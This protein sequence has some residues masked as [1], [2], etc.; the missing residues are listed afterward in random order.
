MSHLNAIDDL[1][2]EIAIIGMSGRFPGAKNI[3]EFWQNL[4]DGVE[5]ISFFSEQELESL[6]INST[7]LK[8]ANYVRA[9]AVLEDVD[10]FDASFFGFAPREANIMDPQQRLFLECAWEA[11]EDAGYSSGTDAGSVGVFAGAS[12]NTYLLLNPSLNLESTPS[13]FQTLISNDKDF[14][15][16]RVSYK[17]NLNGPSI[18]IQSACSTSLVAVHL[19]CQ[20]LLNGECDMALAGGVSIYFPQKVGYLHQEEMIFSPDGHCRAFD[21]KAQGTIKGD[22]LGIVVLKRLV[23]ALADG[24]N[25]YAVIKGSAINNDGSLKVGYT[26]PSEDGQAQVIKDALTIARVMP[27]MIAYVEAHGT[28][29]TLGDPIEVA[30]L[31]QAF[32][33][34]TEAKG[35]C[36]IGSVKTNIGHLDVAAGVAGLIKTVLALKNKLLPPS[37]HFEQPNPHI[38][39]I[40][41]PFYVNTTAC[42]WETGET[43]RRA[44]V[45]SFGIGG[46]NAHVVLEEAP[47]PEF[48][49]SQVERPLHLL[50]LS[51]KSQRALMELAAK[52]KSQL[53]MHPSVPL[54]DVCY[55]A[56]VGRVHFPHRLVAVSETST[57]MLEKLASFANGEEAPELLNGHVEGMS[58]PKVAF[59]FAGQGSQY[60][61]MGRQLYE[62]QPTFR[63]TLARCDEILRPYL[64]QPLLSVL[65]PETGGTSRLDETAY[66]QPALFALEYALF[67]LWRSWSIEPDIVMGHSVGEYVAACVAGVFSLED[68]LK[69]VAERSRLM[70]SLPQDGKMAAVFATEERVK[71]AV[72]AYEEQV[73]IAAVNGSGNI[74]ISGAGEAVQSAIELLKSEGIVIQSLQVSHAFHSPSIDPILDEFERLAARVQFQPPSIPLISNLTGQMFKP[75]E[76]PDANY[77]RR[78]MRET[79]KFS[80][81]M[82]TLA[83]QGY[84]IFLELGPSTTLLSMG[85]R[86]LPKQKGFWLPSLKQGQD[87]WRVLLNS[88]ARLEIQGV[89]V[90]WAGFDRDYQRRRVSLPTYPFERK[91]YWMESEKP[92]SVKKSDPLLKAQVEMTPQIAPEDKSES[93]LR[94]I[95]ARLLQMNPD[96]ID[97]HAPFIEMGADSLVLIEA[98]GIIENTFGIKVAVRQFFEELTTIDALATYIDRIPKDSLQT[99]TKLDV[100]SQQSVLTTSVNATADVPKKE[101]SISV[102][103]TALERI[104]AQ[105]L[106]AMSQLMSQ[107]LEVLR[108]RGLPA[109]KSLSKDITSSKSLKRTSPN[110]NSLS[111]ASFQ[112]QITTNGFLDTLSSYPKP[113]QTNAEIIKSEP[114]RRLSPEQQQHLEALIASYTKRTQKSK[115]RKQAYHPVWAD[116]RGAAGFRLSIKEMLYPI[117]GQYS[118]GS[119]I[120]DIDGNEYIDITMGFGVHLFGHAVPFITDALEARLKQGIHLGP[121]S[122]LAGEV[123]E[124]ICKMTGV[125]RVTFCSSGTEAVM[126][127]LRLARMTTGRTKIALFSG[128]YHGHFD[129]VLATAQT[130]DGQ[131]RSVAIAPGVPQKIIEDVLVLDYGNPQSLEVIQAHA[132]EL[133][134]VLVE[135]VQ[136]RRPDLQ[137]RAF[138]Q[139]LRELTQATGT[140]LIFDEVITGFRIHPGGAQAWFGIAADLVTYG[141]VIGGGMPIGV[142]AGKATYM[143]GIDGGLWNY[144]DGSSPQA[145]KT[146]AAGTFN[147]HPLAM[148]STLAVLKHLQKAGPAL[149]QQLNQRTAQLAETLNAYFE[150]EDVPI[151]IVYFGSLFRFSFSG[152][153]DL[154]FYH[155]I[156]KGV[157]IW[158]GRN[159]FLSTA[160]TDEDINYIIRAVKESVES[161]RTG[162]F[163]LKRPANSQNGHQRSHL[164]SNT[165]TNSSRIAESTLT[166]H[167][168]KVHTVPLTEA[169]KQL[170][171]L[172]QVGDEGAMAYNLPLL[173]E[174]RGSLNLSALHTDVHKAIERHE[175]LRTTISNQGD[176]Q[177]ILPTLTID[178]PL[179]DFSSLNTAERET[180]VQQ[181][182]IQESQQCFD[183]TQGPLLRIHVLK[184][185]AEKHL[186]VFTMHHIIIDGW[187]M[188]VLLQELSVFY[189]AECKGIDCQQEPPLQFREY[190]QWQERQSQTDQ[191][192]EHEAYWLGQFTDSIPILELPS[193]RPRPSVKTYRGARASM[194]L[195]AT[196]YTKCQRLSR[197]K[198]CTLFMTLLATYIALLHRFT[199][200]DDIL[201][202]IPVAGRTLS[203]SENMV[204][205]CTHLLPIRSQLVGSPTFSEY[206]TKIRHVLLDAYEHQDYTFANLLKQLNLRT[207]PSRSPLVTAT[208]NLDRPKSMPKMFGL[209]VELVS[210]PISYAQFDID[211][212]IIESNGE[213]LLEVD[214]STDLFEAQKID[215]MLRHFQTLLESIV[216][217]P[218]Q[219]L[220][221]LSLLTQKERQQLLLEWNHTQTDYPQDACI[222][223]LFEAQV[224]RTPDAVAVVFADQNLT[225]FELNSRANQVAHHLRSLG[226]K[227]GT[228]VGLC[229]S[230]SLE[231]V[232]GLLGILKAGGAYVPLDPAYPSERLAFMLADSQLPVL[233]TQQHLVKLLPQHQARGVCLDTQWP[234]NTQYSQENLNSGVTSNHLAYLIYTSGSTGQPK[235][236]LINHQGLVNHGVAVA[237]E[238][239]LQV[240]DRILQFSSISFDIAAEELF[241]SWLAGATVVLRSGDMVS[242]SMD[243]WQV[244]EQERLT[245][246]NLPT[247]Y[248]HQWVHSLALSNKLLPQTLRLVVV[249]GEKASSA[250]LAMWRQLPGAEHVRWVNTYG[251]TEATIIVTVYEPGTLLASQEIPIGRPI[252]NTQIYLLDRQLQPVPIGIPGEIYIGGVPLARGYLNRPEQ[253]ALAFIRN[254]FSDTPGDRLYKTGDLA[255]YQSN[256]DIEYLGRIDDQVKIRGFRI[257][258]EE[259]E[260]VLSQH[261]AVQETVVIVREDVP[262]NKRLVAYVVANQTPIPAIAQLQQFLKQKLP[263]Y[264]VPTIIVFLDTLPLTPNSKLDR[265][266]LPAPDPA[267]SELAGSYVAPQTSAEEILAKIWAEVLGVKQVSIH[268]NFFELG[269][270]SILSIQIIARANQAG[271]VLTP[272]QLFFNQTIAE[273][274]TVAEISSV[275][276]IKQKLVTGEV[277]LTPIQRWFFE[278]EL[279][280]PHHWNQAMLLEVRQTLDPGLLEQ[281]VEQLL[282]HHDA[283]RL[284]F[285]RS[286]SGWQQVNALPDAVLPFTRVDLSWLKEEEQKPAIEAA[287]AELQASLNLAEGPLVRVALFD[288]GAKQPNRLLFI[289]HHL[290]VDGV[291]WRILLEDLQTT[292]Q[293]LNHKQAIALPPKTTSFQDWSQRLFEYARSPAL[294]SELD[295]WLTCSRSFVASVPVDD[296][297][298]DNTEASACTLSVSLSAEETHALLFEVPKAYH[299]QI[300]DALLTALVQTCAQWTGNRYLLVDLEGH[301]REEIL[302]GVDL[303]RTV[304]W[305]T[306]V[307]PVFL[308]LPEADNLPEALKAVK[309]QL[310]RIP[311]RGIGYGLLR[312]LKGNT[313]ITEQLQ[314]LPQA[315]VSFNYLGQLDQM[316]SPDG[317]FGVAKESSGPENSLRS[318]RSH[319]L[320]INAFVVGGCLQLD[321]IYSNNRHQRTTIEGLVENFVAV[322]RSLI[323]H[324]QSPDVGGYTPSDFPLARLDEDKLSKLA[325]LIDR[326]DEVST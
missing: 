278:Q 90:N 51:A 277:V 210:P 157:Y 315:E 311:Q 75:G 257:E 197:E 102:S 151:R 39:F 240:G 3:D 314:N 309:E 156:E 108:T 35:F 118:K 2:L 99:Q 133:A 319:L 211:L 169:Q 139:Q 202:G 77:W 213:L 67:E 300:N 116:S 92:A 302:E 63:K 124:L 29:T 292:Y 320:E 52:F 254:P 318:H 97:V 208:F 245:V 32:R 244:S 137:P 86:C 8:A 26:A 264:M 195:E 9:K 129:G 161:M 205:Y 79:V 183:L 189:S 152:N 110:A 55:T 299:T 217:D 4:Q 112:S 15:A 296:L 260:A 36:A 138:L 262:G 34:S 220:L 80:A 87:D 101:E 105:Q 196:L 168:T 6:G 290:A 181:W 122:D 301:G 94:I 48:A 243:L 259:I 236:V 37:L 306:T 214:Y 247:A 13:S 128:S 199:N 73:A 162:G 143:N 289:V 174:L 91:R 273:L 287:A 250:T 267:R 64:Q 166:S 224:E 109:Q 175:A 219:R 177:Q 134:A 295:Y 22:G 31:T 304:G 104:M 316:L 263:E 82:N 145:E 120:W 165:L 98:V 272:K 188:D 148:A 172:A 293:Q 154:L 146:F 163:F 10:L 24:D 153:M 270:D 57:Q 23:D 127:A 171:V 212:N 325:M 41:S 276:Q 230:P 238:Y 261:P 103:E 88:L 19:A 322:L 27:D 58:H 239:G 5:S 21:A 140:A 193:D 126:T 266:A 155:L 308:E 284:R 132:H 216:T 233:L 43:P 246:L 33:A 286:A 252:A 45:S 42:E 186:L 47:A 72:A 38:D 313:D 84:E 310:R 114:S 69:L 271:L 190:V 178:V 136:S 78:H 62:T 50:C 251:P 106:E 307:F 95:V 269:G 1:D 144:G 283:L 185:E 115:Q 326:S 242:M 59:L 61:G 54:G 117:V 65:Y 158:E 232:V 285:V 150:Q 218:Q 321:W 60:V 223:Q 255:R 68:G 222:H 241:P 40:N 70:Q 170:W 142:V 12:L 279:S 297:Q 200:Q 288:L 173:L 89:D 207:D 221:E 235:G 111:D 182:L 16:T 225:Y 160:H 294:E 56:N 234:A 7:L 227:P 229:M 281:V 209:E 305:F 265:R 76:I 201:V 28:G 215:R 159:C 258:L 226:I 100:P 268:D 96:E 123:A 203:G 81:G 312:Y 256:G 135:P 14:L 53:A 231:M 149:Q 164:I 25:I 18:T 194:K 179:I 282:M 85:K 44:G 119:R 298:G 206:L 317:M 93:K 249:G 121:Q 49:Y 324:C 187:S 191:M 303:S 280:Q 17:L 184:L 125:E 147:K 20:S 141:K 46:T 323:D 274:A 30:A 237:K 107:Q 228:L 192:A 130:V 291:S 180:K 71:T 275:S 66:T 198:G 204:G 11:L 253:T 131:S 74:V 83:L 176:F 248:W 167:T 113:N